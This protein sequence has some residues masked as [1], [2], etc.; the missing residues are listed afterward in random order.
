MKK[1]NPEDKEWIKL[2]GYSKKILFT[3]ED[4]KSKGIA[5]DIV[6]S[7]SGEIVQPHY[8]KKRKEIFYVLKGNAILWVGN[9]KSRRKP[10]DIILCEPGEMHGVINDT[11]EEFIWLNFKINAMKDDTYWK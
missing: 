7:K 8:H 3:E 5:L 2:K 10:G 6:K 4:L 9:D 1:I 11:D